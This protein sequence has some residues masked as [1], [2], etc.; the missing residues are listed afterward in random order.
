MM[1]TCIGEQNT[2]A[3]SLGSI[4]DYASSLDTCEEDKIDVNQWQAVDLWIDG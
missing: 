4:Q 1:N 2:R 3:S